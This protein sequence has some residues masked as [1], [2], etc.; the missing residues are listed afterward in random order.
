MDPDAKSVAKFYM[1]F[2]VHKE[3]EHGKAPP[4]TPIYSGCGSMYENVSKYIEHF[5]K[6]PGTT[7]ATYLKDTL[8]FLQYMIAVNRLGELPKYALLLTMDVVGLFTNIPEKDGIIAVREALEETRNNEVNTEL[9]VRL[10][11]LIL[12]N[13]I[14]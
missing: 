4:E 14:I 9:I 1:T 12:Q 6:D 11:P 3:N 13:N 10:L 5:I 7:H 2:K 8:D